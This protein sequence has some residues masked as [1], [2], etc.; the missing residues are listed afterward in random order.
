MFAIPP[1]AGSICGWTPS[2]DSND[3]LCTTISTTSSYALHAYPSLPLASTPRDARNPIPRS[4]SLDSSVRTRSLSNASDTSS[5]YAASSTCVAP[6]IYSETSTCAPSMEYTPPS[7]YTPY[8]NPTSKRRYKIKRQLDPSWA[9][10]PPNAFILFRRDYVEKHKG[11]GAVSDPKDKTLSKRAGDAWKA[12][13]EEDKKPW[14]ELAKA[15]AVKHAAA[16]PNYV[17][18]PKKNRAEPRRHPAFLSRREQVEEFVR[19]SSHRRARGF[20]VDT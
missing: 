14:F 2:N 4:L 18:R 12:L 10:R 16:N 3:T 8:T 17:Y 20:F 6:S 15:A 1:R 19:R 13:T 5:I 9:P 11:E 7:E